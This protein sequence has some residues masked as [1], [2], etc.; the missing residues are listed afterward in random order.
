MGKSIAYSTSKPDER[1]PQDIHSYLRGLRTDAPS[2]YENEKAVIKWTMQIY[3]DTIGRPFS[4]EEWI[5]V[6]SPQVVNAF[7]LLSKNSVSISFRRIN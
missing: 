7:N 6:A 2:F 4:P 1:S 5:G 3:W